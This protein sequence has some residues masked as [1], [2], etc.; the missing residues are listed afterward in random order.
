M[1]TCSHIQVFHT[2]VVQPLGSCAF[3]SEV[4]LALCPMFQGNCFVN[5]SFCRHTIRG[6][7][8]KYFVHSQERGSQESCWAEKEEEGGEGEESSETR[9]CVAFSTFLH[10]RCKRLTRA[11]L[12]SEPPRLPRSYISLL[13]TYFVVS[14]TV[15]D[16]TTHFAGLTGS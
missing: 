2:V 11:R 1:F 13:L 14:S 7:L 12:I 15:R 6:I 9:A 3:L 4:T 8:I 16:E 10:C 5:R